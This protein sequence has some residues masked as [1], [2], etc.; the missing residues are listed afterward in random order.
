VTTPIRLGGPPPAAADDP[1]GALTQCHRRTEAQLAALG[2]IAAAL[3]QPARVAE[4]RAAIP[5][6]IAFFEGPARLHTLDEEGSLF[7]RLH[8]LPALDTLETEHRAHE[9]IFLALR[10][11]AAA[12]HAAPEGEAPAEL[13]AAFADHAR[14]LADAYVDHM[15]VEETVVFP[16]AR[17]QL[18][19]PELRAIALEMRLRRGGEPR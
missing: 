3:A 8:D 10:D 9:A 11:C 12:I 19:E 17:A 16:A 13:V 14:A 5:V 6:A 7:P 1:L 2:R 4:A 15:R 18:P